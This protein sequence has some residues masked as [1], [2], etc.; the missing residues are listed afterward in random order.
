MTNLLTTP[1][2]AKNESIVNALIASGGDIVLVA[3]QLNMNLEPGQKRYQP[4]EILELFIG[5]VADTNSNTANNIRAMLLLNLLSILTQAKEHL[6]ASLSEFTASEILRT[7]QLVVEGISQLLPQQPVAQSNSSVNVNFL[8]NFQNEAESA[9]NRVASRMETYN[10]LDT[11]YP[12]TVVQ[13]D[14]SD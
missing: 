13:N 4:T 2:L 7:I 11:E 12:N 6:N 9:R 14:N 8:N 3:E 1:D 5:S 10:K